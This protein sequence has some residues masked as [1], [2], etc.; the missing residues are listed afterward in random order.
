MNSSNAAI[1][2]CDYTQSGNSQGCE[3]VQVE[4]HNRMR[5]KDS[6]VVQEK[7]TDVIGVG[8]LLTPR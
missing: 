3:Q 8:G 7:K 1:V 6:K 5:R 4:T 2:A